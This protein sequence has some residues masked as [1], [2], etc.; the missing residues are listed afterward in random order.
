MYFKSLLDIDT[1]Y[2]V[3]K[4][5]MKIYAIRCN[6]SIS[7]SFQPFQVN[8]KI[9]FSVK[10]LKIYFY[11]IFKLDKRIYNLHAKEKYYKILILY[12]KKYNVLLI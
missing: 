6:R 11:V 9:S 4:T 5:L 3:T 2:F 12:S 8:H 7:T 10:N 1:L